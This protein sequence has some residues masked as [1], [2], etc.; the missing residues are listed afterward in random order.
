MGVVSLSL[1]SGKRVTPWIGVAGEKRDQVRVS[2]G[3]KP[4]KTKC[5]G[6]Q[7]ADAVALTGRTKK[8]R[9]E[10][11]AVRDWEGLEEPEEL[12]ELEKKSPK[13]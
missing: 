6:P 8:K 11:R 12:Q 9:N 13:S 7:L 3:K 2:G 4:K 10:H 5:V 1:S